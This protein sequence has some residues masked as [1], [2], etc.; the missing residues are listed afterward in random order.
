MNWRTQ[1]T[2][3][4]AHR[5]PNPPNPN[6][7]PPLLHPPPPLPPAVTTTAT[8][9]ASPPPPQP[10][11]PPPTTAPLLLP[12]SAVITSTALS[13]SWL[14]VGLVNCRIQVFSAKTG[15]LARTLV[16]HEGGVWGVWLVEAGGRWGG[17]IRKK[18][19]KGERRSTG[20]WD[21]GLAA[22][23]DAVKREGKECTGTSTMNAR[24]GTSPDSAIPPSMRTAL[25]FVPEEEEEYEYDLGPPPATQASSFPSPELTDECSTTPGWG[26]PNALVISGGCDK[27]LRVW[28]L[29]SG[30][31]IHVL[32]GHTSTIRCFKALP[33]L[34]LCVTGSRDATIRIWD[35]RDGKEVRVLR[36]H[37]QSVRCLGVRGRRIVS[38]SYDTTLRV[39]ILV[40]FRRCSCL[41]VFF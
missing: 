36:G 27:V 20:A 14:V 8:P 34:P 13:P 23:W 21:D 38:G 11:P 5:V 35:I 25:G 1:G 3:L 33:F 22:Y 4:R 18:K 40:C 10:P 39:C 19:T 29:K 7:P 28:D 17:G 12:T 2:L 31:C 37:T 32:R 6:P 30:Y 24:T 15:V 41:S 16:G 26:Q 9:T